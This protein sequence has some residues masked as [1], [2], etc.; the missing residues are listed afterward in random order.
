MAV[1]H[2][3]SLWV[4]GAFVLLGLLA[5]GLLYLRQLRS[6]LLADAGQELLAVADLKVRL[7]VNWREER[8]ADAGS[9]F[10]H[11]LVARAAWEARDGSA[12]AHE[13]LLD[14]CLSWLEHREYR[15]A[16]IFGAGGELLASAGPPPDEAHVR[17]VMRSG[18]TFLSDLHEDAAGVV[19]LDLF[20]P[21]LVRAPGGPRQ[22]GLAMLRAEPG[23]RLFSL[24]RGWPTPSASGEVVLARKAG[25]VVQVLF[26]S[27]G[28]GLSPFPLELPMDRKDSPEARAALGEDGLLE[29]VDYGGHRELAAARRVPGTSWSLLAKLDEDEIVGG[30]LRERAPWLAL[31]GAGIFALVVG[32]MRLWW[33]GQREAARRRQREAEVRQV[34]LERHFASLTRHTNDILLLA[35][36]ELRIV[37]ANDR[38]VSAYGWAREELLGK[39]LHDLLAPRA[40]AGLEVRLGAIAAGQGEIFETVHLRR[41]GTTFPVEASSRIIEVEGER[42]TQSVIRDIGKRKKLEQALRHGEERLQFAL[43]ANELGIWDWDVPTDELYLS[44]TLLRMLGYS[45]ER[46]QGG[47]AIRQLFQSGDRGDWSAGWRALLEGSRSQFEAEVRLPVRNG[48]W[49]WV[50]SRSR[51]VE[52]DAAGRPVRLVG[53]V[54]DITGKKEAQER[55]AL[56]D[57]TAPLEMLAAGVARELGTP[58]SQVVSGIGAA[59]ESMA[60]LAASLPLARQ[61]ESAENLALD[62][63]ASLLRELRTSLDDASRAAE[64]A[65]QVARDLGGFLCSGEPG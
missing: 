22:V 42:Y 3:L 48:E 29:G 39:R 47:E 61:P 34:A 13:D 44:A 23:D 16:A 21:L 18:R 62:G 19:H 31:L 56:A 20:I 59:R 26:A 14:W 36:G 30:P 54:A 9:V 5:G 1:T 12:A 35:D 32:V 50:L 52:Q 17:D 45:P 58:I 43:E 28:T 6:D 4:L 55:C 53:T 46:L 57:R 60:R 27:R 49:K 64:R 40:R 8:L 25:D 2:P 10:A 51:V 37:D 11:S 63:I 7:I 33:R 15:T 38:A 41:D 65:S 24:I